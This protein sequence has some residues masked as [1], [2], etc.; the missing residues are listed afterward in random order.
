MIYS[1]KWKRESNSMDLQSQIPISSRCRIELRMLLRT[2]RPSL[3][4]ASLPRIKTRL[5]YGNG[6]SGAKTISLR[7]TLVRRNADTAISRTKCHNALGLPARTATAPNALQT[8]SC[9]KTES[10]PPKSQLV[11]WAL[12]DIKKLWLPSPT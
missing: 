8:G 1:P 9:G 3:R 12:A 6:Q 5:L 10:Y 2:L 7:Y 4:Y 11:H